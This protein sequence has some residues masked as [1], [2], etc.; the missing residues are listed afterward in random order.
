MTAK[1][2]DTE[3]KNAVLSSQL[4]NAGVPVESFTEAGEIEPDVLAQLE[5][6]LDRPT[7]STV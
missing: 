6:I 2:Q 5:N 1:A 4:R 3:R 7:D